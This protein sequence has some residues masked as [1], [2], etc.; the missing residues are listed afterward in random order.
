ML[1]I[2]NQFNSFY[3][4]SLKI[5]DIFEILILIY[6]VYKV[7]TGLKNTRVMILLKGILIL[8]ICYFIVFILQF[9]AL[10]VLFQSII[11]FLIF[12]IIVVFQPEMRK[13]LEQIGTKSITGKLNV[14]S[15]FSKEKPVYKYYSDKTISELSKACI[16]MGNA[17][18]GA[19][20]VIEREIPLT[21]YIETGINVNADLTS[22]LLINIFEKNT[23]LHDGAVVQIKDKVVSAT[24]YLPLS[25]NTNISKHMGTRHRAAIGISEVTDCIVLVVSEETGSIS[26]VVDG[27]IKYN[28]SKEELTS[29]LS[30]YQVKKEILEPN[31]VKDKFSFKHFIRQEN[32]SIRV[33]SIFIGIVGW[34]LLINFANPIISRTIENVPIEFINTS[35]IESTGM[36]FDLIS[37]NTVNVRI[38][39]RRSIIDSLNDSDVTVVADLS[40]LS[41][42]NV[43]P[44][45]GFV[46]KEPTV[47][48]EFIDNNNSVN[49]ELDSII[50]RE[51]DIELEKHFSENINTFVPVLKSDYDSIIV[52]GPKSKVDII[53]KIVFNFNISNPKDVYKGIASPTVYDRNG[54]IMSNDIFSFSFNTLE[55]EGD[56]YNIKEI[57]LYIDVNTKGIDGYSVT[58]I[59]FEPKVIKIAGEEDILDSFEELSIMMDVNANIDGLLNNQL[60]KTIKISDNLPDGLYLADVEDNLTVT[61]TFE[62]YKSKSITFNRQDI[63]IK[64]LRSDY[65]VAIEENIFNIIIHGEEEVLQ[66]I[67]KTT[68]IPFI[69]LEGIEVGEYNLII[70]FNGLENV[71]LESNIS[72][73]VS[74]MD[75]E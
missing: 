1:D 26:F 39:E 40:K 9:Q 62:E 72:I 63:S 29:I 2:L 41:Y 8:F 64:G 69:D 65:D 51:I 37:E 23:P 30:E 43:V 57:P 44:L 73:K 4:P 24:C 66:N 52:T 13:F 53:D 14:K 17:K 12:A 70:Q 67:D 10:L 74:I 75:K 28:L 49:I 6:L 34:F 59:D 56:V 7:I 20:I 18:T 68:I 32:F 11:T 3:I 15:L 50:S 22:Q 60:I 21:E 16:S 61:L 71:I 47:T 5:S 35:I 25:D 27:Q 45:M 42:V 33:A 54:N 31:K 36:T 46:E 48:V 55:V 19:L 58:N 38:T